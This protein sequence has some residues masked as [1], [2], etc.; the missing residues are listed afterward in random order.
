M[1]T[2]SDLTERLNGINFGIEPVSKVSKVHKVN[3]N[4]QNQSS[5]TNN[6]P[7]YVI[8]VE[9]PNKYYLLDSKVVFSKHLYKIHHYMNKLINS[10]L[11][12][13]TSTITERNI[14]TLGP[15]TKEI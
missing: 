8:L 13:A 10:K 14:N 12:P 5:I 2:F 9:Y 11:I 6:E 1:I 15:F 4:K 3:T 7:I